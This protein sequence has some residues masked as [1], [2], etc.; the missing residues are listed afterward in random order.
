MRLTTIKREITKN[1]VGQRAMFPYSRTDLDDFVKVK[2]NQ[3]SVIKISAGRNIK[4]FNKYWGI[5][6]LI[7]D[8]TD[9]FKTQEDVSDYMKI[10]TGL[11]DY[12]EFINIEG[13]QVMRIKVKS[14]AWEKMPA[15][16]FEN[17]YWQKFVGI[18][19]EL[20][21]CTEEDINNNLVWG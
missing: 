1:D 18:A 15:E 20:L 2:N 17:N 5:C 4:L 16:E 8:N 12:R 13:Q 14:I 19:C 9:K 21:E 3:V 7:L 10:K 6:K 11:V